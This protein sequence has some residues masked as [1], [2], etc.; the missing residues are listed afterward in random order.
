M[1]NQ[2]ILPKDKELAKQVLDGE[3]ELAKERLAQGFLGKFW[4]SSS[5]IPNNIAGMLILV[6]ILTCIIY[7]FATMNT[8][9]DK[10]AF[11]IKDFWLM[12]TPLITL[13]IGYLFGDK[14]KKD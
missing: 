1:A 6:L 10:L 11:P 14:P 2:I 5:S 3:N 13:A 9:A 8:P 12:V 7:T 4:G